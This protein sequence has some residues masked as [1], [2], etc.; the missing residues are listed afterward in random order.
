[1]NEAWRAIKV[2]RNNRAVLI[3]KTGC[4]KTTLARFLI[5]DDA[6]PFSVTWNP[7]GSDAIFKWDHKHVNSLSKLYD[8][9][10]KEERRIVYTPHPYLAEDWKNQEELFYYI[11]EKKNRRFYIDEATSIKFGGVKIPEGLTALINRGREPGLST[12]VATQRPSRIPM[13]I[14]SESEHYYI[15]RLRLPQDRERVEDITGISVEDQE[16]LEKY[17]FFYCSEEGGVLLNEDGEPWKIK[18][19]LSEV[20]NHA[21]ARRVV[22]V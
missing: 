2:G 20:E 15:F 7:K 14:L 4:G 21:R 1:M 12:M 11:Y 16:S 22:T 5:E 8:A 18:L 6:K 3:G 13:N 17:E 10:D 19:N 9:A